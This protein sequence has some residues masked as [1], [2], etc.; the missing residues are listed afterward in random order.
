M[1]GVGNVRLSELI[2][3]SFRNPRLHSS[4]FISLFPCLL[5]LIVRLHFACV[6]DEHQTGFGFVARNLLQ[7]R[8]VFG[9]HLSGDVV[10]CGRWSCARG[11]D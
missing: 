7:L 11:D 4:R 5:S 3:S 8:S 1:R 6:F 9:P 10:V 2:E